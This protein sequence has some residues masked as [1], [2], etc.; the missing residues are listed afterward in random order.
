MGKRVP[1][2]RED[3]SGRIPIEVF[4][5]S[6]HLPVF[7]ATREHMGFLCPE[8]VESLRAGTLG[9]RWLLTRSDRDE[10]VVDREPLRP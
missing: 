6:I 4:D 2:A 1:C 5:E 10:L 3:C 7:K 8:C 9:E